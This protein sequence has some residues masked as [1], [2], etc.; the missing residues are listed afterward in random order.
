MGSSRQ[1]RVCI[2]VDRVG[3]L[4]GLRA[5]AILP[6]VVFHA[7]SVLQYPIKNLGLHPLRV[8]LHPEVAVTVTANVAQSAEAAQMQEA[9]INPL[10]ERDEDQAPLA[11][12]LLEAPAPGPDAA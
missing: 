3:A 11:T 7:A 12:E 4:D 2:R 5:L 9:G 8:M 1:P 10:A 6:V